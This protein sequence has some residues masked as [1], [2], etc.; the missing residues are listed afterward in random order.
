[1]RIRIQ[2]LLFEVK[3]KC[4]MC[5]RD[6]IMCEDL[7]ATPVKFDIKRFLKILFISRDQSQLA[8]SMCLWWHKPISWFTG[9]VLNE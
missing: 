1:M 8:A 9:G 5:S 3:Q 7:V 2:L 6:G 4:G